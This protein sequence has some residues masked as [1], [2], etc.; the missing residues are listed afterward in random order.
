MNCGLEPQQS[1]AEYF[2]KKKGASD[3]SSFLDKLRGKAGNAA[4]ADKTIPQGLLAPD[5]ASR[6]TKVVDASERADTETE[7][8]RGR[9]KGTKNKSRSANGGFV[10][11]IDC[12]PTKDTSGESE[13]ILFEDWLSPMVE[14]L[15]E[16]VRSEKNL[17]HYQLLPYAEEKALFALAM[18]E[19]IDDLPATMVLNSGAPGAKD[20]LGVLIP[21]ASRVVRALRG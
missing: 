4:P 9:P 18:T 10:L 8:K 2:G 11:Y 12:L 3:M 14:Q 5:A 20:A 7:K 15:N 16:T 17:P 21:H 1:I 6:E 13:P 19:R